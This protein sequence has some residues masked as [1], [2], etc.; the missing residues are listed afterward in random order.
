MR[1][2]RPATGA[3]GACAAAPSG[4]ERGLSVYAI[5]HADKEPGD[6][7]DRGL[8]S[9]DQPISEAGRA[10][11]AKLAPFFEG[12]AI[13]SILVSEYRRTGETIAELA[14]RRGM[15]PIVE[16]LLNEIDVGVTEK[17][18]DE[19]VRAAYPEF[20]RDYLARDRDFRIPGGET[21]EEA[22]RRVRAVFD[23]LD[24]GKNHLLVAHEGLIRILLCSVLGMPPYKRHLFTI[25]FCSICVFEYLEDFGCWRIPKINL[26]LA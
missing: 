20:W 7:Y 15:A 18:S 25:G 5:R 11:A 2:P 8:K 4:K 26:E 13:D 24:R 3:A 21:G 16:P 1:Y 17:M 12:I 6:F 22:E 9:N 14:A 10:R 23:S 19:E